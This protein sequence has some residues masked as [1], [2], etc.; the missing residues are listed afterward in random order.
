MVRFCRNSGFGNFSG[1]QGTAS[2]APHPRHLLRYLLQ[3]TPQA[4]EKVS[5]FRLNIFWRLGSHEVSFRSS[6]LATKL[7]FN[8]VELCFA[9]RK[10]AF[11]AWI[12]AASL[13][14][15]DCGGMESHMEMSPMG[16]S[17][18]ETDFRRAESRG[19]EFR[20]SEFCVTQNRGA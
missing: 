18:A 2:S 7:E 6:F 16:Q 20:G 11:A 17:S 15:T 13:S 4:R 14:K 12:F 8:F 10:S 19:T 9:A 1:E 5:C 3:Y